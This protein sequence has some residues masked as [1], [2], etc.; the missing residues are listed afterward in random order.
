MSIEI[1]PWTPELIMYWSKFQEDL[2]EPVRKGTLEILDEGLTREKFLE[3]VANAYVLADDAANTP[4]DGGMPV[5]CRAGCNYC[6]DESVQTSPPEVL[7]LA[8][9]LRATLTPEGLE[10]VKRNV[11]RVDKQTHKMSDNARVRA[12]V[13]CPLLVEARCS[14]YS[15]RPFTC[16]GYNSGDVGACRL[17]R[18]HPGRVVPQDPWR[19]SCQSGV[20]TGLLRGL[21]GRG[22]ENDLLELISAL[23][24]ALEM[25]DATD[26]WL[27]GEHIF[28]AARW[29]DRNPKHAE[30]IRWYE[31]MKA[32]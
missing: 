26:R 25:P 18:G 13:G 6:C 32:A 3:L 2:A 10:K 20:A 21:A 27:A 4:P 1:D 8:E 28:A 7:A 17:R 22:L 23:R 12:R 16:R 19:M 15:M 29:D 24:I 11:R 30:A 31:Q 5:V 14:V 9:Y